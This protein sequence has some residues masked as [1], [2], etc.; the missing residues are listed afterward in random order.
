M[1]HCISTV[2]LSYST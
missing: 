2:L 1:F